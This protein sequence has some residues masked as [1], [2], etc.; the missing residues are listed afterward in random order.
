M[1]DFNSPEEYYNA[2]KEAIT[3][4]R[5]K[6][7]DPVLLSYWLKEIEICIKQRW[8]SYILGKIDTYHISDNDMQSLY[9]KAGKDYAS[10]IVDEMVDDDLLQVTISE[11]G[12]MLY[13]LTSK[14]TTLAKAMKNKNKD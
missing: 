14:G 10:D 8:E 2:I 6:L 13:S 3:S 12:E 1:K 9:E 11:K 7:I 4:T 5:P